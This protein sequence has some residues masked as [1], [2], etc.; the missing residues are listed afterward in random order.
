MTQL[1]LRAEYRRADFSLAMGRP[2]EAVRILERVVEAEPSHQA[3]LELL[4]V[5]TSVPPEPSTSDDR[6]GLVPSSP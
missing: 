6:R 5:P 3:A 4:A 2:A 1:D